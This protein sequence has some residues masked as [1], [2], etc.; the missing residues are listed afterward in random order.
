LKGV[1][2]QYGGGGGT[3]DSTSNFVEAVAIAVDS[4]AK[5]VGAMAT[6]GALSPTCLTSS[7]VPDDWFYRPDGEPFIGSN[8]LPRKPLTRSVENQL[9][10]GNK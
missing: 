8:A 4:P 6:A 7:L 3:G 10:R 2:R 5:F 9:W 1:E